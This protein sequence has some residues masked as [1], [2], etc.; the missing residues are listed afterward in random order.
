MINYWKIVIFLLL[1]IPSHE[2]QD[3]PHEDPDLFLL[4]RDFREMWRQ[5]PYQVGSNISLALWTAPAEILGDQNVVHVYSSF[6]FSRSAVFGFIQLFLF[7]CFLSFAFALSCVRFK[8]RSLW[9]TFTLSYVR[10][11]LRSLWVAFTLS[12]V[13]VELR[14]LWVAFTLSCVHFELRSLWVAFSLSCVLFELRSLWVAFSLSCVLF[15]LRSLWVVFTLSCVPHNLR[16]IVLSSPYIR[17]IRVHRAL[18]RT[19]FKTRI[20]ISG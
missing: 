5:S 1:L 19:Y 4:Q 15:E 11:E 2:D 12:Y 8:L 16:S 3:H 18:K 13:H 10:V 20:N 7:S 9:V 17:W 14:S 6:A